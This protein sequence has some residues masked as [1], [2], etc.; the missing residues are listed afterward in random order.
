MARPL[1][2]VIK[3][4]YPLDNIQEIKLHRPTVGDMIEVQEL[5]KVSDAERE[6]IMFEKLT[7]LSKE[8]L[9]QLD[10]YDYK[11]LQDAYA[12]FTKTQDEEDKKNK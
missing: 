2:A 8:I 5:E 1:G 10:I 6:L 7:G 11:Q 9:K 4:K 3:L 12:S